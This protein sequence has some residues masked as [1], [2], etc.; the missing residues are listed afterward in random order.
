LST[1]CVEHELLVRALKESERAHVL[2]DDAVADTPM[3][4]DTALTAA[5]PDPA[6]P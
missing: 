6:A 3:T 5:A 1:Y 4:A 2:E